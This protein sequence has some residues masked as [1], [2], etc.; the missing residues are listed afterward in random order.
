MCIF[1]HF[2]IISKLNLQCNIY[3]LLFLWKKLALVLQTTSNPCGLFYNHCIGAPD[4]ACR[5]KSYQASNWLYGLHPRVSNSHWLHFPNA[6]VIKSARF[7]WFVKKWIFC[8]KVNCY[9]SRCNGICAKMWK[10]HVGASNGLPCLENAIRTGFVQ[11]MW[12]ANE[13]CPKFTY[14]WISGSCASC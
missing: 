4:W 9:K 13:N 6:V 10:W 11:G 5:L 12:G 2:G 8:K 7:S 3:S 1:M 14:K